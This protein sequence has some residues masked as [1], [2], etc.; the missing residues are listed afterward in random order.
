[1]EA[2]RTLDPDVII[3][4]DPA[5]KDLLATAPWASLRAVRDGHGYLAPSVPFG[6]VEE[7][8]SINRLLG[9]AWLRGGDPITLAALF[10]SVVYGRVLTPDALLAIAGTA[11]SIKP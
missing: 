1:V 2:I 3:L 4:S 10:N 7:P 9:V 11:K 6:W 8:P 5:A